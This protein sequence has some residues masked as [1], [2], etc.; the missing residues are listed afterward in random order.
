MAE[1]NQKQN[2][3]SPMDAV[4]EAAIAIQ[5]S[6]NVDDDTRDVSQLKVS[7]LSGFLGAGKTTGELSMCIY[8][9]YIM[10]SVIYYLA[11]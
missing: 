2:G 11:I 3:D 7:V 5:Q 9:G 8:I 1:T 4:R 6:K 10:C